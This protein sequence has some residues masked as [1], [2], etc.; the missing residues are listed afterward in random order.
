MPFSIKRMEKIAA[1]EA[2]II[3]LGETQDRN[4]FSRQFRFLPMVDKK[5]CAGP[6][7]KLQSS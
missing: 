2:A 5:N 3:P 7:N 1:T 6:Y 4:I